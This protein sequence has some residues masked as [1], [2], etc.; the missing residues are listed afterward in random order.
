MQ[1]TKFYFKQK[2]KSCTPC[3][4]LYLMLVS[5]QVVKVKKKEM[6]R[7]RNRHGIFL[8]NEQFELKMRSTFFIFNKERHRV[9]ISSIHIRVSLSSIHIEYPYPSIVIE[10]PY[11]YPS[12]LTTIFSGCWLINDSTLTS[13]VCLLCY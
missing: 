3:M 2:T 12:R 7:H 6:H 8:Y 11:V 4:Y 1:I 9:S 10:Y 13:A 5:K